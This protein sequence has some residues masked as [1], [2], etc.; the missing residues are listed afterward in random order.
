MTAS[1]TSDTEVDDFGEDY[2]QD[3]ADTSADSDSG[4]CCTHNPT[5]RRS[6]IR[7][8]V[9]EATH[10][11]FLSHIQASI[12][13]LFGAH[14]HVEADAEERPTLTEDTKELLG[15]LGNLK[16]GLTSA[17]EKINSLK[18]MGL[19]Y[20]TMHHTFWSN[21]ALAFWLGFW[22]AF[23]GLPNY[24]L[25]AR[26]FVYGETEKTAELFQA[27]GKPWE[28]YWCDLSNSGLSNEDL[29]DVKDCTTTNDLQQA[30]FE[31][32]AF[33]NTTSSLD[34]KVCG[35]RP[36]R[37]Y[38][39]FFRRFWIGNAQGNYFPKID[40]N[41]PV[42]IP[43]V[44]ATFVTSEEEI[45]A[46]GGEKCLKLCEQKGSCSLWSF[47]SQ[48]NGHIVGGICHFFNSTAV[49]DTRLTYNWQQ[50]LGGSC[51]SNAKKEYFCPDNAYGRMWNYAPITQKP[52]LSAWNSSAAAPPS[53]GSSD[54]ELW[55]GLLP[56]KWSETWPNV[57]QMVVFSVFGGTGT[58]IQLCWQ[59]FVGTFCACLN[60][61]VMSLLF[62][63]GGKGAVCTTVQMGL[64]KCAEG[65]MVY[66][67]PGYQPWIGWL[68]T[69]G[70]LFL[71]MV[72]N[73][74]INTIKFGMSWHFYFMMDFID[75]ETGR[76][77][78]PSYDK[79]F[80]DMIC[81]SEYWFVVLVTTLLGC[82]FAVLV[83]FVPFPLFNTRKGYSELATVTNAVSSVWTEAVEYICGDRKT[84][85]RFRLEAKIDMIGALNMTIDSN[86]KAAW[87]ESAFLCRYEPKRQQLLTIQQNLQDVFDVLP[88]V[89]SCVLN[90]DFGGKHQE[91]INKMKPKLQAISQEATALMEQCTGA[92]NAP[93]K[94]RKTLLQA[95]AESAQHI[96][97]LQRDLVKVY[98]DTSLD[99]SVDLA[100]ETILVF[101]LSFVARKAADLS[102]IINE[103]TTWSCWRCDNLKL[104]CRG[105]WEGFVNTWSPSKIFC[106]EHLE[107]AVR[108]F[109][110][111]AVVF[112]L[113]I[114]L[115]NYIF[116]RYSAIMPA[117][118]ALLISR[119]SSSA[120][121]NNLHRLL[122]VLLGKVL[123]ILILSGL[124][125][126][127]CGAA[128]RSLAAFFCIWIYITV[129][130]YMYYTSQTWSL[131]GC[132][133]AGFGVYPLLT[134]CVNGNSIDP[135]TFQLRY[136][137]LGQITMA[138][139][140]QLAVDSL[141][142]REG[143]A[144]VA[145]RELKHLLHRI[146]LGYDGHKSGLQ[147]IFTK[148]LPELQLALREAHDCMAK[149]KTL[150]VEADP[151]MQIVSGPYTPF[152]IELYKNALEKLQ[153]CMVCLNLLIMSE[154]T[155]AVN[156]S[157]RDVDA[158][159]ETQETT[160]YTDPTSHS[161][162]EIMTASSLFQAVEDEFLRYAV[163]TSQA[164]E[165]I[166][167]HRIEAKLEHTDVE[168]LMGCEKMI[169]SG[170]T[171]ENLDRYL[172]EV[173]QRTRGIRTDKYELTN[174]LQARI[175]VA[176]RS[177][178]GL[179]T[180][181]ADIHSLCLKANIT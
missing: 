116:V 125:T 136:S 146:F 19:K 77:T 85:Q 12:S 161:I 84:A 147:A 172:S 14:I 36:G 52:R 29:L 69:L 148:D 22:I 149:A 108:N 17:K 124:S 49:I 94:L 104:L 115:K 82:F 159:D 110:G 66:S 179:S 181:L 145:V 97:R 164:L 45:L 13:V 178:V 129:F 47:K 95:I 98:R 72:S 60:C 61:F 168:E 166:L 55:C 31:G 93:K 143:P 88:A 175:V 91:F 128:F 28:H 64:G 170:F 59:G 30:D 127:S 173:S 171:F 101:G 58:T 76:S 92:P 38:F 8:M 111:M 68:D 54:P 103:E 35:Y 105:A 107:F 156:E 121:T 118:L 100:D 142:K 37:R 74:Q 81:M 99:P 4:V 34:G 114:A 50:W 73:S 177:F 119:F 174:N 87:W 109:V 117:T 40:G 126:L 155:W 163:M 51:E 21:L 26:K 153:G 10:Q 44:N 71:F 120:F 75:P 62:P 131:V 42:Y 67:S 15:P 132:L 11:N 9:S 83:T 63:E 134:P 32:Q 27:R 57:V 138:L 16:L 79:V 162:L 139:A 90:E 113:A 141:L 6:S 112:F 144:D 65:E 43:P 160:D 123:P 48:S 169:D 140:V 154:K 137:E 23:V 20:Q 25:S 157:V 18:T 165:A 106:R 158:H 86:L 24:A 56:E 7:E 80:F 5:R 41:E 150:C 39:G 130:S 152:K 53:T 70:V 78:C 122:G 167:K 2:D 1:D 176:M 133:V 33:L 96:R 180:R 102:S 3:S 135:E 46:D 89:K 151:K